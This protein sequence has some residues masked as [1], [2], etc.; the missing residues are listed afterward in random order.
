MKEK[1]P[2][3]KVKGWVGLAISIFDPSKFR[4]SKTLIKPHVNQKHR[5]T[6]IRTDP[7]SLT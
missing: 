3:N 6:I 1:C 2:R 4:S 7:K 5:R